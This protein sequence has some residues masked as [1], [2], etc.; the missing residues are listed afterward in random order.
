[1]SDQK[2]L[3]IAIVI[4]AVI[5]G[6]YSL[7]FSQKPAQGPEQKAPATQAEQAPAVKAAPQKQA[8]AVKA[9][10][11]VPTQAAPKPAAMKSYRNTVVQT[12]MATLVFS[13]K[14]GSLQK[15]VLKK[16]YNQPGEKGGPFQML[17]LPI[18][19]PLSLG[20]DLAPA[21]PNLSSRPFQ[22]SAKELNVT[23]GGENRLTYTC[24]SG[25]LEIQ[26]IYTFKPDTY[27]FNLT[28]RI[29]NLSDQPIEFAN[30]ITL[31]ED[32]KKGQINQYAFTGVELFLDG[33][34]KEVD[35]GDLEDKNVHSGRITWMTMSIPY[36][37]G[38]VIPLDFKQGPKRSM[39]G[40]KN[41][42]MM[43]GTL[44]DPLVRLDGGKETGS[45]YEV[46]YGPRE[47]SVLKSVGHDLD[48]AVDFGWFDIMAK[49]MLWL[50][51][52]LYGYVGN[53]GI[54]IIII[55]ILTKIIFY[56]LA[57]KQYKSM[58]KMQALQPQVQK[59]REKYKGDKQRMNQ[60]MMQLYKTYKV[61]PA[62]GCLPMLVQIPVFIAFYK[63]LGASIELRHAPFMLW[64]N[65]LSAPDRLFPD[66]GLP[67]VGGIP[68]MVLL[69]GAT[70]FIQQKMTPTP[71][72][73]SQAKIML[74]M[75]VVFTFIFINF[76]SG[77]VLY[78][79]VQNLLGIAQQYMTNK[80]KA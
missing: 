72:D 62:G 78:W 32:P 73:P 16:Y 66:L 57:Q 47:L 38:A 36:F 11:S 3:I 9:A 74:L 77:L 63:V 19:T 27:T 53:Y 42:N 23:R 43:T 79:F 68:V 17:D 29:K 58:K 40:T 64:I 46:F 49:P 5:M 2:R 71:G 37:M 33:S 52:F 1:M 12:D 30:E 48:K 39:R 60:E 6:G 70:M 14:G 25:N 56:P 13:E 45:R 21:D 20:I 50:L 65:D 59:I 35:Q 75:P 31:A 15:V 51:N 41:D 7:L 54:A 24:K 55:T 10:P 22:A 34:M 69:M 80:S 67:Y 8:S 26:K 76:P 4:S 44:I 61:N 18:N 28:V